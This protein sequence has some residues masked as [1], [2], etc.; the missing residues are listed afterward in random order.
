MHVTGSYLFS[1]LVLVAIRF[2]DV[3]SKSVFNVQ[4]GRASKYEDFDVG[5]RGN[6]E[7]G[8][9]KRI[10]DVAIECG[11]PEVRPD[12]HPLDDSL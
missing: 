9:M 2:L 6:E 1:N 5:T 8:N 12:S 3:I 4:K 11:C 10:L 7:M